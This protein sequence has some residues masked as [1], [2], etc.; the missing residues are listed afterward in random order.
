MGSGGQCAFPGCAQELIQDGSIVGV[1]AHIYPASASKG[2]RFDTNYPKDRVN[3]EDNCILLCGRHH[4]IVDD[5]PL[6]YTAS[7]LANMKYAHERQVSQK[8]SYAMSQV[9]FAAISI[10]LEHLESSPDTCKPEDWTILGI[11][12][13]INRNQLSKTTKMY[14]TMGLLKVHEVKRFIESMDES[15]PGFSQ[16]TRTVFVNQYRQER[17]NGSDPDSIFSNLLIFTE[18]KNAGI[19]KRTAALAILTYLFERCEVFEK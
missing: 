12:E 16:K 2:P 6:K 18:G 9:G 11:E 19:G 13:K 10:L 14:M 15:L 8:L 1:F 3:H 17:E 7:E 5:H 4:K